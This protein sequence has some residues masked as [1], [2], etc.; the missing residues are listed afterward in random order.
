MNQVFATRSSFRFGFVLAV[1]GLMATTACQPG[2]PAEG[3]LRVNIN[4]CTL[5][6]LE[7]IPGIGEA[8]AKLIVARR[9]YKSVDEL[10]DVKGIGPASLEKLR[11]YVKVDGGTEKLR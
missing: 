9:P 8:L 3:S 10:L 2:P 7:T 11:T 4:A 1:M 6:E 5:T